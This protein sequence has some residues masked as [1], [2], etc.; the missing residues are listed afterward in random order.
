MN[1]N[2]VLNTIWL[3]WNKW[4]KSHIVEWLTQEQ[5][6]EAIED[7]VETGEVETLKETIKKLIVS[8]L[9]SK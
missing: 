1:I 4:K 5:L 2:E 8:F 7:I 3:I 6:Q 9:L